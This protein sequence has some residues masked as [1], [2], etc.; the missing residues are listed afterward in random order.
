[1][2]STYMHRKQYVQY[3]EVQDLEIGSPAYVRPVDHP[4]NLVSNT[5]WAH[6]T[7]VEM[8]IRDQ[9]GQVI[10]FLTRNTVY[11]LIKKKVVQ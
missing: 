8:I 9:D 6:T 1:M 7:P 3:L 10:K 4:S 11:S 2:N 5:M